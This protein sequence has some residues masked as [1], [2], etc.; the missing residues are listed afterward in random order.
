MT[1]DVPKM[2]TC[3]IHELYW[4]TL[5]NNLHPALALGLAFKAETT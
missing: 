4:N 3:H 1:N 5:A 2:N